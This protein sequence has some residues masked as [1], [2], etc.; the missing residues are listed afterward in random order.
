MAAAMAVPFQS[1]AVQINEIRIDEP[2]SGDPNEYVELIGTPG[3]S[4]DDVWYL[5][6]GD[7]SNYQNP[8]AATDPNYRTGT[9][10]YAI[11]LTGFNIPDDGIFLIAR[12]NLQIDLFGLQPSDIDYLVDDIIF[13]NSDN[14]T[15]LLVKG[16]TGIEVTTP[17]DQWGTKGVDI[18]PNDDGVL[19]DPLPWAQ[20]L[21]AIGLIEIPN[22]A[23]PG[24]EEFVYGELLGFEDIG[25]DRTFTPGHVFRGA[26][27]SSWNI[28]PFTLIATSGTELDPAAMDTPGK[29]NND[30]PEPVVTPIITYYTPTIAQE[31]TVITVTGANLSQVS[32]VK[33]DGVSISEFLVIDDTALDFTVPNGVASGAVVTLVNSAGETSATAP[34]TIVDSALTVL[35]AEDFEEGLGDFTQESVASNYTWRARTYNSQGF[36]EMSGFGADTASDDWL[37]SPEIDLGLVEQPMLAF[38][39]ARNFSGPDLEVKI[40]KNYTDSV[41]TASWTNLNATVAGETPGRYTLTPSGSVDLTSYQG[42]KVRIAFR[43]TSEGPSSG[44]GATYQLHDFMVTGIAASTPL[45]ATATD[46]SGG[47][48]D[49]WFG[50]VYAVHAP[51]YYNATYRN[52]FY[53]SANSTDDGAYVFDAESGQWNYSTSALFPNYYSYSDMGWLYATT[54]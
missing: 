13:E 49:T 18:D 5:V 25:P 54:E 27:D 38:T 15:H 28:G 51:W 10:E 50:I 39:S 52:W 17:A 8:T 45:W 31:G 11:D 6:L 42:Q 33:L 23:I 16:Y 48:Y 22:D 47:F 37:V 12:S 36:A 4:L 20:L 26:N 2:G 43:Y 1:H 34:L 24:P 21:D 35:I 32:D 41:G 44:Q 30:S 19:V 40:S 46:L 9:V 7:H 53:F 14:V 29:P 3:E